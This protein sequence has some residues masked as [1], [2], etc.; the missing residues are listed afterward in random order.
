MGEPQRV[1][2]SS[3]EQLLL[4]HGSPPVRTILKT[5][6]M[7]EALRNSLWNVVDLY[8]WSRHE[9]STRPFRQKDLQLALCRVWLNIF[10][11]PTDTRA[12]HLPAAW[13]QV[14]LRFLQNA[15]WLDAYDFI[16][17][18]PEWYDDSYGE[19]ANGRARE[20]CNRMLQ[21][22]MSRFRF[23]GGMLVRITS[24]EAVKSI[25]EALAASTNSAHAT[26]LGAALRL[27]SDR[28][29]RD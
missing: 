24:E 26:H 11:R 17:H 15:S 13:A 10:K 9:K 23:V 27:L 25:K 14:R 1:Q 18:L 29:Q 7:D 2:H 12:E 3:G 5:D 4:A 21:R 6:G 19:D 8:Y 22:E 28:V 20:S 16:E